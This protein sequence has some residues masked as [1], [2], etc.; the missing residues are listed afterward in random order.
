MENTFEGCIINSLI[1]PILCYKVH[2]ARIWA[3]NYTR[4][5]LFKYSIQ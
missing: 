5:I 2:R 4:K 3:K 1:P